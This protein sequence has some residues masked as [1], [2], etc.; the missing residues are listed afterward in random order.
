[1]FKGILL[2]FGMAFGVYAA[3]MPVVQSLQEAIP[4]AKEQKRCIILNFT[5]KEWC[6]AC[7][8]LRTKIFASEEFQTAAGDKYVEAEVIFPRNPD[9]VQALGQEK[10]AANEHLLNEYHITSGLPTMVL[11]DED[12]LPFAVVIGTRRTPAEFLKVLEEA[13]AV[14][15]KRDAAF[16]KAAGLQGM[17]RAKVLAD[18]LNALPANC[19]GKYVTEVNEINAADPDN[20]LGFRDVLAAPKLYAEQMDKFNRLMQ[21]FTLHNKPEELRSQIVT[22]RDFYHSTPS[23]RPEVAQLIWR[24]MSDAHALL[25]EFDQMIECTRKALEA[26]PDSELAPRLRTN[27]Q[28]M[29]KNI[30]AIKH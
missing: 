15:V 29:E 14:R 3:E 11:H 24:A 30:Q 26:A 16:A 13:Q 7:I 19:R 22:L 27:L 23:L 4:I 9:A 20:T 1:M 5:G 17:E 18:A 6:P 10:L 25:R 2:L 12:G 8:H 21:S 28:Y